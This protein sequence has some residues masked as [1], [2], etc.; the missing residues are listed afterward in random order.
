MANIILTSLKLDK[1]SNDIKNYNYQDKD[2]NTKAFSGFNSAEAGAKYVISN[3]KVDKI[4]IFGPD[5]LLPNQGNKIIVNKNSKDTLKTGEN[6]LNNFCYGIS[7]FLNNEEEAKPETS[8]DSICVEYFKVN[9]TTKEDKAQGMNDILQIINKEF[10][11]SVYI[12]MEIQTIE[13]IAFYTL[14]SFVSIFN[15]ITKKIDFDTMYM[16]NDKEIID[17][18]NELIVSEFVSGVDAFIK[19]GKVDIIEK[20]CSEINIKSPLLK[21]LLMAIQY[22]DVGISLNNVCE[23]RKGIYAIYL[24]SKEK[25]E[26]DID[27]VD[28]FVFMTIMNALL[29]DMKGI[30]ED[31]E[32]NLPEFVLWTLRKGCYQ[33]TLTIIE[34]LLPEDIVTRGI[35]YYAQNEVE[36]E[37]IMENWN[38]R[39]WRESSKN[40]Y[41]YNDLNHMYIK[42]YLKDE[43]NFKQPRNAQN[44]EFARKK[45]EQLDKK[46]EK[47]VK[48]YTNV[49]D[50]SIL[51]KILENYYCIGTFRNTISHAESTGFEKKPLD[52]LTE[53]TSFDEVSE[54]INNCIEPYKQ[55]CEE[56]KNNK[57]VIQPVIISNSEFKDYRNNHNIYKNNDTKHTSDSNKQN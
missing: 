12:S 1:V 56:I 3:K 7:K 39:Y 5:E 33:Q 53:S 16:T 29:I 34:A 35:Y 2:G 23:L 57:N 32:I 43:I 19:H 9:T 41:V 6:S 28:K 50:T 26:D 48:A 17:V 22:V 11:D 24:I 10:T 54:V 44:A 21:K 14:I 27:P 46:Y 55:A 37:A 47:Y 42:T 36:K 38:E 31:G 52:E 49:S 45:I 20:L 25:L 13:P 4:Y 40:R 15:S 8:N 30:I 18:S 51:Q